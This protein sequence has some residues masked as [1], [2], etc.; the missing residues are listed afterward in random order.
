MNI[1]FNVIFMTFLIIIL[2]S[3][4]YTL[5]KILII[6]KEIKDSE[7]KKLELRKNKNDKKVPKE[8]YFDEQKRSY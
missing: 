1:D 2:V 6:L 4:Q 7:K 8:D 3:I 5:N